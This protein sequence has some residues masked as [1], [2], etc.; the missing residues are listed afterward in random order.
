MLRR[1]SK[2]MTLTPEHEKEI[3]EDAESCGHPHLCNCRD[4][5]I[6][7]AEID[8][9]RALNHEV[10]TLAEEEM[11]HQFRQHEIEKEELFQE[12]QK[13]RGS[14]MSSF[15]ELSKTEAGVQRLSV[16]IDNLAEKMVTTSRV[17]QGT[18]DDLLNDQ[19]QL[20]E[21][22]ETLTKALTVLHREVRGTLKAHEFAIRYD[23][24]NSNWT[25]LEIA[26]AG[27]VKALAQDD[28]IARG[29]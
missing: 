16:E 20:R 7:L 13:A 10:K 14:A 22:I 8:R 12:V 3:R 2:Y 5:L 23:S 21:R 28:K 17:V 9:L 11:R 6:L 27:A 25:C 4:L 29:E 24:G 15:A 26:M 18:I 1:N 19:K